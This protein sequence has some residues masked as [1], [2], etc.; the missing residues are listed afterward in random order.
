MNAG[1][2][3]R[4]AS[5]YRLLG[6]PSRLLVASPSGRMAD[7]GGATHCS[8]RRWRWESR[9]ASGDRTVPCCSARALGSGA[10]R[11]DARDQQC[12]RQ[13]RGRCRLPAA[14][15]G[16]SAGTFSASACGADAV[17][18]FLALP[19]PAA[20][21]HLALPHVPHHVGALLRTAARLKAV[22]GADWIINLLRL[23]HPYAARRVGEHRRTTHGVG[24]VVVW[25]SAHF[26]PASIH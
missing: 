12:L 25:P 6:F 19:C 11:R 16:T 24:L 9:A 2:V 3:Q 13:G 5:G 7:H 26:L 8:V 21:V 20:S 18:G 4:A 15:A 10:Q 23:R 22:A 14:S 17:G 1:G